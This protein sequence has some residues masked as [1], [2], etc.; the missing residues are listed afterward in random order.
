[1]ET[2]HSTQFGPREIPFPKREPEIKPPKEPAPDLRPNPE[3]DPEIEPNREKPSV[4]K[5][6]P[7]EVPEPPKT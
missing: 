1:M 6:P 2:F 7:Q 3:K 4:P 5:I